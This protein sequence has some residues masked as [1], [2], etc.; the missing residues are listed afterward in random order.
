MSKKKPVPVQQ[1]PEEVPRRF[2]PRLGASYTFTP[3]AFYQEKS[4]VT[5]GRQPLPRTVTGKI[6][7]I[8]RAH[9]W[10]RV[11]YDLYGYK[12]SQCIKF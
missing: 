10:F 9:S 1:E 11:E 12:L 5:L 7:Q 6:V 2:V 4:S 8:H 3:A